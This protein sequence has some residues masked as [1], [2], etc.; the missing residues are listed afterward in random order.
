M[1]ALR[2]AP[3]ID[4]VKLPSVT[5]VADE[6]YESKF[7]DMHVESIRAMREEIILSTASAFHPT[8][9]IVDNV[10]LE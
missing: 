7:L 3:G 5:K 10:P 9:L 2:T 1:Q 8:T 4:F 6:R